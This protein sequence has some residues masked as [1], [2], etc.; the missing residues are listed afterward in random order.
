MNLR[1]FTGILIY[2]RRF[3]GIY[4]DLCGLT[5]LRNLHWLVPYAKI[6]IDFHGSGHG[7]TEFTWI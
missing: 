2:L 3:F 1:G 4:V 7:F 6:Y 5:D